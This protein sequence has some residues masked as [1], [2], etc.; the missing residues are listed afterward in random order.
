MDK[1]AERKR[2]YYERNR[3]KIL[4]ELRYKRENRKPTRGAKRRSDMMREVRRFFDRMADNISNLFRSVSVEKIG[5]SLLTA[6]CTV[7]LVSESAKTLHL[8]EGQGAFLAAILCEILLVG[9]SMLPVFTLKMQIMR[10]NVVQHGKRKERKSEVIVLRT[11]G[12]N[13]SQKV[14]CVFVFNLRMYST[15]TLL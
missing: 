5:V 4:G 14:S 9:V 12:H 10:G 15:M 7:Y 6:A 3:N 11:T 2:R 1:N 8:T 13:P